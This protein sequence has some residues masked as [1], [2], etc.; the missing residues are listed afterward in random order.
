MNTF[1]P[2]T[3]YT[4]RQKT[5]KEIILQSKKPILTIGAAKKAASTNI[6]WFNVLSELVMLD[7][8]LF[9]VLLKP[10]TFEAKH[11]LRNFT[12]QKQAVFLSC[13]QFFQ[14]FATKLCTT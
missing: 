9:A 14:C 4:I 7:V 11:A 3:G 10:T 12:Q 2:K 6:E 8:I 1:I 13:T 5:K